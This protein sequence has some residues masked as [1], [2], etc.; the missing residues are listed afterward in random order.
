MR[1]LQKSIAIITLSLAALFAA[2]S[3]AQ[4]PGMALSQ[5]QMQQIKS[6][7]EQG[8][9]IQQRIGG[10]QQQTITENPERKKRGEELDQ[11]TMAAMEAKGYNPKATM[12]KMKELQV[13][14]QKPDTSDE[15]KQELQQAFQSKRAELQKAQQSIAGNQELIDGRNQLQQ[16]LMAAMEKTE[17][18]L[19]KLLEQLNQLR[20]QMQQI[21]ASAAQPQ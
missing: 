13:E 2:A 11:K 5:E 18:E 4:Q 10:I 17:P 19:P 9:Q 16:D 12:E 6:L 8:Q 1:V 3:Q 15:R 7:Q 14:Y 21:M 20:S